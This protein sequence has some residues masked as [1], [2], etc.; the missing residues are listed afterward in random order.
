M[1]EVNLNQAEITLLVNGKKRA[2][3]LNG[4]Y[5]EVLTLEKF[6]RIRLSDGTEY[7]AEVRLVP[8]DIIPKDSDWDGVVYENFLLE[9]YGIFD[10]GAGKVVH[11][12]RGFI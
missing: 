11:Q 4:D 10:D 5:G 9:G 2:K 12:K 6:V 3:L 7:F 8:G 1:G